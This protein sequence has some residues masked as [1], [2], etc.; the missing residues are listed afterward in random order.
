MTKGVQERPSGGL[1]GLRLTL[2]PTGSLPYTVSNKNKAYQA[3][4]Q[5][6][7][8]LEPKLGRSRMATRGHP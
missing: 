1:Y 8:T 5:G 6:M 4:D 2:K 7:A 3:S